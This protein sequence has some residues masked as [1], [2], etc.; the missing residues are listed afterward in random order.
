MAECKCQ[1]ANRSPN[2]SPISL[3]LVINMARKPPLVIEL[4]TSK[5]HQSKTYRFE[6][7]CEPDRACATDSVL[8]VRAYVQDDAKWCIGVICIDHK[9]KASQ[10]I[11]LLHGLVVFSPFRRGGVG[12]R[13]VHEAEQI[14]IN[15]GL[16]T[17]ELSANVQ[18]KAWYED[19]GYSPIELLAAN[20]YPAG[21][22]HDA[23][24]TRIV[25]SQGEWLLTK[26]LIRDVRPPV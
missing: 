1:E 10:K 23:P 8:V 15:L 25:H 20:E 11:A 7:H 24:L 19:M 13:L 6:V 21:D 12:P 2:V 22:S 18:L 26:H 14:A 9:L 16:E 3:Q 5:G 17:A 4:I